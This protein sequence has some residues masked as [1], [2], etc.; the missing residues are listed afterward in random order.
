MGYFDTEPF[1]L[2]ALRLIRPGGVI[3][4][5]DVARLDENPGKLIRAIGR[6]C[7]GRRYEVLLVREA[8]TFG[9][10]KSHMVVDFRVLE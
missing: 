5:H 9:P 1:L 10:C 2:T 8:K 6:A 3:R 7:A 4:Y